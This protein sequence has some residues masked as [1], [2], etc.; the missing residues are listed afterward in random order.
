MSSVFFIF[1]ALLIGLPVFDLSGVSAESGSCT[2]ENPLS[3]TVKSDSDGLFSQ[4]IRV[5]SSEAT[6]VYSE[7][8]GQC[9]STE[10]QK[11]N[12]WTWVRASG[13]FKLTRGDQIVSLHTSAGVVQLDKV[14]FT[15][16]DKCIPEL[17]GDNCILEQTILTLDGFE[18]G[19]EL[20]DAVTV[21]AHVSG[22]TESMAVQFLLDD[23]VYAE[24]TRMGDS[25]VYCLVLDEDTC[26]VLNV[27]TLLPGL[28][29]LTVTVEDG[30]QSGSVK[31]QFSVANA[32]VVS[33]QE[34][35]ASPQ[36][37][38]ES[39][40][41]EPSSVVT[42]PTVDNSNGDNPHDEAVDE[43]VA[44]DNLP[45]FVIGRGAVLSETL[46]G[47]VALTVPAVVAQSN[48]ERVVYEVDGSVIG[49]STSQNPVVSFDTSVLENH[50]H[51][52]KASIIDQD[53]QVRTVEAAAIINNSPFN[54][55]KMWFSTTQARVLLSVVFLVS[56]L[57]IGFFEVKHFI[58][59][60]R[61]GEVTKV[62]TQQLDFVSPNTIGPRAYASLVGLTLLVMS[63][64][65]LAAP[66][67][68]AYS[69]NAS[70]SVEPEIA[71]TNYQHETGTDAE[72][73]IVYVILDAR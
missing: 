71:R 2:S 46:S 9:V 4:W 17:E 23:V 56:A 39:V 65:I 41:I 48:I 27:N 35:E 70:I 47:R 62:N 67:T 64:V 10:V 61:L 29:T 16:D 58:R 34:D 59:V 28:H 21:S 68:P 50:G 54:T 26:G 30:D 8:A 12:A 11:E 57:I 51:E 31:K 60:R 55:L 52:F 73:G 37:S 19:E 38:D 43:K 5:R 36:G 53:G 42:A 22:A 18:Q 66:A 6:E 7:G 45:I 49:V 1:A 3:M 33:S 44:G 32:S 40:S 24:N 25:E 20:R 13:Y 15:A 69:G 63:G 14:L 72:A